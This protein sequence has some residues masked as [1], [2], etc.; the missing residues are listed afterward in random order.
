MAKTNIWMPFYIGDYMAATTGLSTE[1]HGAYMLLLFAYWDKEGPL[2]DDDAAFAQITR[3]TRGRWIKNR[4]ILERFFIKKDGLWHHRRVDEELSRVRLKSEKAKRGAT[5][6]WAEKKK[7]SINLAIDDEMRTQSDCIAT[8]S[9]S[10]P[11]SMPP[12]ICLD[13]AS[14]SHSHSHS[15]MYKHERESADRPS[16]KEVQ[17]EA[18]RI[19]LAPWKAED[20]FHEM[21]GCGWKDFQN[22]EIAKWRPVLAR[23]R[24]KW[25]A[26]GRP[27]QPPTNAPRITLGTART[28]SPMDIKTIIA[29][30]EQEANTIK[31]RY[32]SETAIDTSW[33]NQGKRAEWIKLR[34]EIKALNNRLSKMA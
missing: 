10:H 11:P 7:L 1:Q 19:G 34:G 9:K 30:K 21:E 2:T 25:E 16:L 27:M 5:A 18:Q 20:W 4:P 15:Q 17:D 14:H 22:R 28:L 29:A 31:Q 8:A 32:A 26:D 24:T 23:V 13:D 3:L 12:S 6:L 33:N